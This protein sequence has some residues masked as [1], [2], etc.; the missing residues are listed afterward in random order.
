MGVFLYNYLVNLDTFEKIKNK[1]G[2]CGS[3]A[4]WAEPG[5]KPKSNI[6][7]LSVLDP[8]INKELL[9]QLKPEYVFVGLNFSSIDEIVPFANFH[10]SSPKAQDFKIRYAL[11]NTDYWGSYMTDII[12]NF[13][14]KKSN[15]M[16]DVLNEDKYLE[17]RNIE[18]FLEEINSLG[19]LNKKII[20][21]GG[22]AY[23]ILE[24]NLKGN[25]NIEKVTHY[26][27]FISKENYRYEVAKI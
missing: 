13:E 17:S 18:I 22:D 8:N 10:S 20:A 16:M 1:Y 12:K 2:D 5:D 21:F 7:D 19:V 14:E 23:K 26:S 24:R 25:Y 11:N 6:G 27:H 9:S 15:K 4:I 3:W